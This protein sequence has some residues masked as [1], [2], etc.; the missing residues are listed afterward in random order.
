MN[1]VGVEP[2]LLRWA[3]DRS[4][5]GAEYLQK[6]FPRLEAWERGWTLPTLRQL[7]GFA[8]ATYTP[9]GY[10]FLKE[11][12][13]EDLPINDFRTMG[14]AEISRPSPDLLDTLYLSQQRQDW[15]RDEVRTAGESPLDFVGSMDTSVDTL[16]A[17]SLLRG[18]LR[19]DLDQR[20]RTPTWSDALRQFIDQAEG[21]GILVMVSGIVAGNTHRRLDP[22]EFR[23]FV[24]S[25]HLAPLIFI[26][27][28]DTKAAQMFTL[29]HELA[30]LWLGES[31]VSNTQAVISPDHAV[32][33]W[34]NQVAA[35]LLAPADSIRDE[36][37][38][39]AEL[40]TEAERL[41]RRFKVSTLVVLRRIHDVGGLSR[42]AFQSV[43]WRETRRLQELQ[44]NS[45]GGNAIK[46]VGPRV[47][48]RLARALV[49]STLE[50]RTSYTESFHL[51]GVSR[52]S[53]FNS[54][55]ESLGVV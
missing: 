32:E 51:L 11:P 49:V 40:T 23:G 52:L 35:E 36:F 46:N 47:S 45:G 30:H 2:E 42:D 24:L 29:A 41:A 31:G 1:R 55:A 54:V 19:F 38:P 25:D 3:R 9:I 26:N 48:K 10:L 28:A 18:A 17:G 12:P 7:E 13:V 4:G 20:R 44:Q 16:H 15:Y 43:Y 8:K 27:G 34:C 6:R 33:R 14:N 50:G 22:E 53:T 37:D 39:G 21:M 5:R